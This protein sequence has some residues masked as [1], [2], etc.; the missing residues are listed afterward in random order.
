MAFG[1]FLSFIPKAAKSAIK[2]IGQATKGFLTPE[3]RKNLVLLGLAVSGGVAASQAFGAG[4]AA[5]GASS[6]PAT[7]GGAGS[8]FNVGRLVSGLGGNLVSGG[9]SQAP[10]R[11]APAA[12]VQP[13]TPYSGPEHIA[14]LILLMKML[15]ISPFSS[16]GSGITGK[17]PIGLR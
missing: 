13:T 15:G 5:G 14:G 16:T 11:P 4:S 12:P 17:P 2:P 9:Q 8:S 10:A 3:Q 6:G 1:S 7:S